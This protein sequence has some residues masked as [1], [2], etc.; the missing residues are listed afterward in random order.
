MRKSVW[1]RLSEWLYQMVNLPVFLG[2]MGVFVVFVVFILPKMAGRLRMIT[3]VERSPDTSLFY[4]ATDLY[5]MAEAYGVE[6][7]AYYIYQRFTFD[8]I[9][10]VVYLLFFIALITYLLRYLPA[11]SRW[12]LLNLLPL[13]AFWFD[14]LENSG[15]AYLMYRYPLPVPLVATLVPL[16]TLCKWLLIVLS[17]LAVLVAVILLIT[18]KRAT[19]ATNF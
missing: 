9:W 6:G 18:A 12:R 10:P 15:A 16:F 8:L 1:R 2:A 5:A 4:K 11:S 19:G 14:L 7:R 13:A 3:G 17:S